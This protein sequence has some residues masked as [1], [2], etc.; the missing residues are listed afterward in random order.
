MHM[1]VCKGKISTQLNT[2][3]SSYRYTLRAQLTLWIITAYSVWQ[4]GWGL[5]VIY[6]SYDLKTP[7]SSKQARKVHLLSGYRDHLRTA[8]NCKRGWKFLSLKN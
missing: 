3:F 8:E 2:V 7:H 5:S 1:K 4:D 6:S